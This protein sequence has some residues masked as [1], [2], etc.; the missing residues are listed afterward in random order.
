MSYTQGPRLR[1]WVITYEATH[2]DETVSSAILVALATGPL[3][4]RAA[5]LKCLANGQYITYIGDHGDTEPVSF[6][7]HKG[8]PF[9]TLEDL[10]QNT[11]LSPVCRVISFS[12]NVDEAPEEKEEEEAEAEEEEEEEEDA[13]KEVKQE[14]PQ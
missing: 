11:H 3:Q 2:Q 14:N 1:N 4:A 13:T 7:N 6:K 5:I 12:N 8:E 10:V 9:E